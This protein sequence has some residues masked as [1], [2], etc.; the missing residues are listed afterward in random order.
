VKRTLMITSGVT[1]VMVRLWG[2]AYALHAVDIN[3]WHSFPSFMTALFV[4]CAGV[5]LIINGTTPT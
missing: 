1:L 2:G 4:G 3:D 5:G